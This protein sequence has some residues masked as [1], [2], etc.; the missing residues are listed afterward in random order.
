MPDQSDA[1]Q[2]VE[3]AAHSALDRQPV[4]QLRRAGG[5]GPP[6]VNRP[7]DVYNAVSVL[8]LPPLEL[9]PGPLHPALKTCS[10]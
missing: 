3:A 1:L 7:T 4:D 9:A 8:H 5:A 6:W 10:G 2:P